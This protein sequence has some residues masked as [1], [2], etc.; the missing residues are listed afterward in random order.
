MTLLFGALIA[1]LGPLVAELH[2]GGDRAALQRV[3]GRSIRVVFLLTVPAALVMIVA[4]ELYLKL[5]GDGFGEG[6]A[7]L[8]ILAVA[9]LAIIGTGPVQ[10]LLV[11][12][13]H[14]ARV[15]PGTLYSLLAN[16]A[17]NMAL[18]PRFGATGA[19][20]AT[21]FSIVLWN[22]ALSYEV[23]RHLGIYPGVIGR[24]LG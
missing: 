4:G 24:R 1:P 2:A 21:A 9:Q 18:I 7:A 16:L 6:H 5:F 23:R 3:V 13:G 17:L 19:A 20:C 11:M 15:L 22:A 12:T 8:A 14:Q 10:M